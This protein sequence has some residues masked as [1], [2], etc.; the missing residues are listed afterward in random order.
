MS[1]LPPYA[2]IHDLY[3][4][5]RFQD[6]YRLTAP[7]WQN[8][9]LVAGMDPRGLI[10]AARVA[11]RLG[12]TRFY[13]A[14]MRLAY[15]RG[16]GAPYVE[17]YAR[18]VR[19]RRESLFDEL[20]QFAC[21]DVSTF[22]DPD[23]EASWLSTRA[24]L[25]AHVRDFDRAHDLMRQ[26]Y[27]RGQARSYVLSNHS[28]ILLF[29]DR[30]D[31]ALDKAQQAWQVSP[32][33]PYA[34]DA[35]LRAMTELG[36]E[37]EAIDLLLG[38]ARQGGQCGACLEMAL[39]AGAAAAARLA[40]EERPAFA[41]GLV[42]EAERLAGLFPLAD[43]F[44]KLSETRL[45]LLLAY[46]GGDRETVQR[47]A[48][49]VDIPFYRA[50]AENLARNPNG[51]R[52]L[53]PHNPVRQRHN[54]CL[55][56]SLAA[57]SSST[58]PELDQ[59]AVSAAISH[60]GTSWWRAR[61]Y[62][63][64]QGFTARCFTFTGAAARALID[65]G[66]PFMIS[67]ASLKDGHAC[68]VV[69]YDAATGTALVHDPG[70]GM[71]REMLLEG[72]ETSDAPLGPMCM[73]VL[74]PGQAARFAALKLPNEDAQEA[75]QD[76][77]RALETAS[78]QQAAALAPAAEDPDP[79]ARFARAHALSMGAGT[80]DSA[81]IFMA[82][83]AQYPRCVRLQSRVL[84][85]VEQLGD[86]AQQMRTLHSIV[87]RA[88][89]PG[90]QGGQA[91]IYPEPHLMARYADLLMQDASRQREAERWL[92]RALLRG[93]LDAEVYLYL[94]NLRMFEDRQADALEPYRIAALL[95]PGNESLAEA[96][97]TELFRAGK[98]EEAI[99]WLRTRVSKYGA[100]LGGSGC[101]MTLV[102]RLEH[103]G[104]PLEALQV[105]AEARK[106]RPQDGELA[107]FAASSFG[108]YGRGAEAD[109]ALADA[110]A[111]APFAAA[112]SA[113]VR[114]FS[115]EGKLA[116][117]LGAARKWQEQQPHSIAACGHVLRLTESLQGADAA[118]A[119]AETWHKAAPGND[120]FEEMVLDRL[121]NT[122]RS[123]ERIELLRKRVARNRHDAW[124][125]RELA[126]ELEGV[127]SGAGKARHT[128][129]LSEF[130]EVVRR[131]EETSPSH[132]ITLQLRAELAVI[133]GK[134]ADAVP[135]L[136]RS[137]DADPW[138][139]GPLGRVLELCR[140]D[141]AAGRQAIARFGAALGRLRTQLEHAPQAAAIV[142][143][144]FGRE[145]ALR[146]LD[147]WEQ[148]S[149]GDPYLMQARAELAIERGGGIDALAP[150]VPCLEEAV[151]RF[152][153]HAG[154]REALA[155]CYAI[156]LRHADAAAQLEKLLAFAAH[157]MPAWRLLA[158]MHE[159]MGQP[160]KAEAVLRRALARNPL[161]YGS[162]HGLVDSLLARGKLDEADKVLA[163]GCIKLPSVMNL[164][165]R[166]ISICLQRRDVA[167]AEQL[168]R[169]LAKDFHDG[170]YAQL[171]LA[172]ALGELPSASR[173]E[174]EAQYRKAMQ[175]NGELWEAVDEYADFLCNQSQFLAAR[176]LLADRR[177]YF[178]DPVALDFKRVEV[179]RREK[180]QPGQVQYLGDLL[181]ARPDYEPGWRMFIAWV[182]Q[183]NLGKLARE[184]LPAMPPNLGEDVSLQ[185]DKLEVLLRAGEAFKTIE[186]QWGELISNFPDSMEVNLR[187]FDVLI[188]RKK[189]DDADAVLEIYSQHDAT[190]PQVVCR[191]VSVAAARKDKDL[192]LAEMERLCQDVVN[193]AP[194]SLAYAF[195]ALAEIK[196]QGVAAANVAELYG[197]G[198]PLMRS[199]PGVA[200][201][202]MPNAKAVK[203]LVETAL[204]KPASP[205]RD[206]LVGDALN[207]LNDLEAFKYVADFAQSQPQ[208][209]RASTP[210]WQA[211]GFA[212]MR[213]G[214][215]KSA[216]EWLS[217]WRQRQGVGMWAVN[218]CVACSV[219]TG[220]WSAAM[221]DGLEALHALGH[222]HT[223][224]S[225]ARNAL[226]ACWL[227]GQVATFAE[228]YERFSFLMG[229]DQQLFYDNAA[230]NLCYEL[231]RTSDARQIR[232]LDGRFRDMVAQRQVVLGPKLLK[233]W[234][235]TAKGK[236]SGM[237]KFW[238]SLR[239]FM[240]LRMG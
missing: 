155:R 23:L 97:A 22:G 64:Q 184:V 67:F 229:F 116:E 239:K 218:A 33:Q 11:H 28:Q 83:L 39:Y 141:P 177:R 1:L 19:A 197:Q 233:A 158:D 235:R 135:L 198:K 152:P 49:Q 13:I 94:G 203:A 161:D 212:R 63:R 173:A 174:I 112:R 98:A 222:D 136:L 102:D 160:E 125:W 59:D 73:A 4:T 129:R 122:A 15:E 138:R 156:M 9:A 56:A 20:Q 159:R 81:A 186:K 182:E 157:Y 87:T 201:E 211:V 104:R 26:A 195:G 110:R 111:H 30:R 37:R 154:L 43:R 145:E 151:K 58:G 140:A 86:T 36:R 6:I 226:L 21:H 100:G 91:W 40:P 187:W 175:L 208:L 214:K 77:Y 90:T 95:E 178:T 34:G 230:L 92:R 204:A 66:A 144:Y 190:S 8:R 38:Y 143:S 128:R 70:G 89:L 228:N 79:V 45:R 46:S 24:A 234:E 132:S 80:A 118:L 42:R 237:D 31:E 172:R 14:L 52:V 17:Y 231:S 117:A 108:H 181:R 35:L 88:P 124:A 27:D 84:G 147:Q 215:D 48:P 74:R 196:L 213:Q 199:A 171:V 188:E 225:L 12:N 191:R 189:V 133:S 53:L 55:P 216:V 169:K 139:T 18:R 180:P 232:N 176:G 85:A 113:E 103:F 221:H 5:A 106:A 51:A 131:C 107:A 99:A 217:D 200:L 126:I 72:L 146:A 162:Y 123:G 10:L 227:S 130:G 50:V 61:D 78:P 114:R 109:A 47:L 29:E 2:Q 224:P 149:P 164:H 202:H 210:V 120:A 44:Q 153:V 134:P 3:E 127:A 119:L 240:T 69:G 16:K 62:L 163:E 7:L 166:R 41:A 54:T 75:L 105:L 150:V 57:I 238:Y 25:L 93:P 223:A 179:D 185:C 220:N 71:L 101:Y 148:Y 192:A 209:A 207:R 96:Y 65:G 168:A 236:L 82:L 194:R 60:E 183:D 193:D 165:E 137:I 32:G 115:A 121:R 205:E 142:A 219:D 170:A 68:A 206:E 167:K 76:V